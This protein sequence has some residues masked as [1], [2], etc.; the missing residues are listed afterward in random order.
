MI[1]NVKEFVALWEWLIVTSSSQM[2]MIE[3]RA[4]N[5]KTK[6]NCVHGV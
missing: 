5:I 6:G 3:I 4:G 2:S 1:L